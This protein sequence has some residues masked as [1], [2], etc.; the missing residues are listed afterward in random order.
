MNE[1]ATYTIVSQH[2]VPELTKIEK[3]NIKVDITLADTLSAIEYNEKQISALEAELNLKKAVLTNVE[4]NHPEVLTIDEVT[5]I[6]C[7][8]YYETGRFVKMAEMKLEEFRKAQEDLKAEVLEIEKQTGIKKMP[9]GDKIALV[10]KT[11][12]KKK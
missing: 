10:A 11:K 9:L 7:H 2:E 4:V 1:K 12:N 6:A 8:T 5:Q 3:S